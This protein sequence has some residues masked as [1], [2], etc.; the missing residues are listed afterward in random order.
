MAVLLA[1]PGRCRR[2]S[3]CCTVLPVLGLLQA[4]LPAGRPC[5]A[6]CVLLLS[7]VLVAQAPGPSLLPCGAAVG[8]ASA[9]SLDVCKR[10]SSVL[11]VP[12][13]VLARWYCC[14]CC[15]VVA[16]DAKPAAVSAT[17][18]LLMGT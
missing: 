10:L 15:A 13:G 17:A 3:G 9:L 1:L 16:E 5:L 4:V 8:E 11:L 7:R 2:C 12:V 18:L 6:A 14:C